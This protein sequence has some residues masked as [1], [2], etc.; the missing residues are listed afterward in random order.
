[1]SSP[2]PLAI[3]LHLSLFFSFCFLLP[4][5]PVYCP[6]QLSIILSL[7]VSSSL[8]LSAVMVS[9]PPTSSHLSFRVRPVSKMNLV[10]RPGLCATEH[11]CRDANVSSRKTNN[12]Q[13]C[14]AIMHAHAHTVWQM[15]TFLGPVPPPRTSKH[16]SVN[17]E[18]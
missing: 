14:I 5:G 16:V 10:N 4:L 9:V 17:R 3:S 11:R 15:E 13:K 8:S 1:M 12:V 7:P 6:A 2:S 18:H